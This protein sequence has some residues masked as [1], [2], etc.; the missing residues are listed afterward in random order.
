M[1][2]VGAE[3]LAVVERSP[4]ATAAHDRPGWVGLF[5]P[6][7]RVEDPYGS[8]P[9]VGHHQIGR[10]YDT[11]VAP[12]RV[13]FH[14]DVDVVTG[15]AVVRDLMLKIVMDAGLTVNVPMHLRYHLRPSEPEWAVERLCAHWELPV[16]VMQML[17]QGTRSLP[18]SARLGAELLRNQGLSGT[19]GFVS[20]FVRPGRREKRGVATFLDAAAA[21]DHVGVRVRSA[22]APRSV[23][24]TTLRSQLAIW[25]T[26]CAA[27]AG[28]S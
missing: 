5:T 10:F 12:R 17:R 19:A 26:G 3:L 1:T 13:I 6:D 28:P 4:E 24:V 21:G 25:S 22:V 7:G 23:S 16:M 15:S 18:V 8:R 20:G 9:H 2:P 14:R 27:A 11:F